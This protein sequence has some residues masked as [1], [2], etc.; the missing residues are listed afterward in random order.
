MSSA[1]GKGEAVASWERPLGCRQDRIWDYYQ[2][3]SA[4]SFA[5][6]RPRLDF[7]IRRIRRYAA[8]HVVRVL[9]IG[10]GDGYFENA[11]RRQGWESHSLDPN[12]TTIRRLIEQGIHGHVGRIECIPVP[13][14]FF[15]FVVASEVL[16]HLGEH[17]RAQGLREIVRVLRPGGWLLG[18]VPCD[19]DLLASQVVCPGCGLV[20]HRWGHQRSFS[21]G[22]IR[23]ELAPLFE[24]V[25]VRRTAFVEF[26]GQ[27]LGV[28]IKRLVRL[29]AAKYGAMLAMPSIYFAARRGP[30][31]IGR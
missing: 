14:E 22:D 26:R 28:K 13:D 17:E 25:I 12:E 4:A 15:D 9:N 31:A 8:H 30:A 7:L 3:E 20:F 23:T 10:A 2:N 24:R 18:T 27:A 11:V 16:E 19:E 1:V 29:V 5:L 6:A 21:P